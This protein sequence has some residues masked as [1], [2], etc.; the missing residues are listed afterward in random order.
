MIARALSLAAVAV[1]AAVARPA[2]AQDSLGVPAARAAALSRRQVVKVHTA[3][4][5]RFYGTF[6]SLTTDSLVLTAATPGRLRPVALAAVDTLWV[7]QGSAALPGALVGALT[8]ASIG[9]LLEF[10]LCDCDTRTGWDQAAP[11]ATR[12][13]VIGAA[14]GAGLGTLVSRWRRVFP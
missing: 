4:G 9:A 8:L 7:R 13:A 14:V 3:T 1:L 11:V 10:A 6:V 12:G 5:E 2:G